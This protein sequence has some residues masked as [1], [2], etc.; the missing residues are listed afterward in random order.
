MVGKLPNCTLFFPSFETIHP[1]SAAPAPLAHSRTHC[2]VPDVPSMFLE[3]LGEGL[4]VDQGG[5]VVALRGS[6]WFCIVL[7][8]SAADSRPD[9]ANYILYIFFFLWDTSHTTPPSVT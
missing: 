8:G 9:M 3:V 5:F 2:I 1:S 4:G 7:V 6:R